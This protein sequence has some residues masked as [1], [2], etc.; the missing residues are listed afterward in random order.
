MRDGSNSEYFLKLA[1]QNG[2]RGV[3]IDPRMTLS[4]VAL[5]DE[6]IPIRP[7]TDTAMMSAMAY[8]MIREGLVDREFIQSHCIGFDKTQMPKGLENEESYT[9]YI[10]G[11]RDGIP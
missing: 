5:A 9:D 2:A 4:A 11:N 8:I 10:L 3:C 7:G 6:R 1:R